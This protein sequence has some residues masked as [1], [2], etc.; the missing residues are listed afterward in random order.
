MNLGIFIAYTLLTVLKK[1]APCTKCNRLTP[2][3][4]LKCNRLTI[5]DVN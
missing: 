3:T 4:K 1:S 5:V 2:C